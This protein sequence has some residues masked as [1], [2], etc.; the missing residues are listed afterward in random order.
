MWARLMVL[1]I[2]QEGSG[3]ERRRGEIYEKDTLH[4]LFERLPGGSRAGF[5]AAADGY[6]PDAGYVRDDYI[7]DH[8]DG[9]DD[10]G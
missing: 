9:A 4:T 5:G 1:Y 7:D 10:Q 2:V 3:I 6:D 8:F